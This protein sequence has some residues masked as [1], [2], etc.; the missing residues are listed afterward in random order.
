MRVIVTRPAAQAMPWVRSL[1]KHGLKAVALPLIDIG[2]ALDTR[3]VTEAWPLGQAPG[4]VRQRQCR[5][6]FFALRPIDTVWPI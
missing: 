5:G 2:P 3:S 4:D 6:A 1:E